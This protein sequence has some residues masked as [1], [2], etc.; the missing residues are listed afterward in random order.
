[1]KGERRQPTTRIVL[2]PRTRV[3]GEWPKARH[4]L[5]IADFFSTPHS[6]GARDAGL[7]IIFPIEQL[8]RPVS[9]RIHRAVDLI[10][11]S[12]FIL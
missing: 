5:S 6:V 3:D 2:Y 1:M 9:A 4:A 10:F 12:I 8:S 11:I 7:S